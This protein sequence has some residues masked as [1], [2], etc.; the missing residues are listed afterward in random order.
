MGGAWLE[1]YSPWPAGKAY[2]LAEMLEASADR[3]RKFRRDGHL[4]TNSL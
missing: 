2:N 3:Y 1:G 4:K